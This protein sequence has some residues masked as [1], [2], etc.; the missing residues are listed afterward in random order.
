ML[1]FPLAVLDNQWQERG[2]R[3]KGGGEG[4]GGGGGERDVLV[5]SQ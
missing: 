1:D 3:E 5:D 2:I 4:G